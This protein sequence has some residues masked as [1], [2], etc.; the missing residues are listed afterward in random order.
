[1]YTNQNISEVEQFLKATQKKLGGDLEWHEMPLP[2][3][4]QYVDAINFILDIATFKKQNH[5][6]S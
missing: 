4:V 6:N 5:A 1:M 2:M 3:Q